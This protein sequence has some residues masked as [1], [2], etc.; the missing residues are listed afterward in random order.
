MRKTITIIPVLAL[1]LILLSCSKLSSSFDTIE[2]TI[3]SDPEKAEQ[4]LDELRPEVRS[5][6][7]MARYALL[8]SLA[9]DALWIDYESDSLT[10]VALDYYKD[11]GSADEKLKAYF[12]HA[13]YYD[14]I[15]KRE[16]EMN[17]LVQAEEFIPKAD[18]PVIAGRLYGTTSSIFYERL[19]TVRTIDYAEKSLEQFRSANDTVRIARGLIRLIDSY[20]M[21]NDVDAIALCCKEVDELLDYLD[22]DRLDS[23]YTS[24]LICET[25]YGEDIPSAID[26]YLKKCSVEGVS[27]RHVA[28]AYFKIGKYNEAL[29]ALDNYAKVTPSY[30]D[31]LAYY[32]LLSKIYAAIGQYERAYKAKEIYQKKFDSLS[33]KNYYEDTRF[34]KERYEKD[35][36]IAREKS[37]VLV[38]SLIA[39]LVFVF[40]VTL[41]M[42]FVRKIK[43]HRRESLELKK[44]L[45]SANKKN[46]NL[47]Q[48]VAELEDWNGNVKRLMQE[49]ILR[50]H[51]ILSKYLNKGIDDDK[52]EEAIL[53][54]LGE[55]DSFQKSLRLIYDVLYPDFI[56]YLEKNGLDEDDIE[57]SCLYCMG[58]TGQ[59]V[60]NYTGNI[61]TYLDSSDVRKKFGLTEHKTNIAI[62]LRK[63]LA[64]LYPESVLK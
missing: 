25:Y 5:K 33:Q 16:T 39:V 18:D 13:M 30:V 50:F 41:S 24:K 31:D 63:K 6:R 46:E 55:P 43:R 15:G 20:C 3:E 42:I 19:D 7:D 54:A 57:M 4:L 2:K 44:N 38:I 14:N 1:S 12:L 29:R 62:Y 64:E 35:I 17:Y 28:S 10:S 22:R 27:W 51:A 23:Y 32:S 9:M 59:S 53:N 26:D 11:H 34:L 56:A 58:L 52:V 49:E 60:K 47:E 36:M 37:R 21:V 8:K 45:D 61:R 48:V 40:L